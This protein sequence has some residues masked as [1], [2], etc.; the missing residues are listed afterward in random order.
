MLVLL[1]YA[2]FVEISK[3]L[4]LQDMKS[5]KTLRLWLVTL[6][7]EEGALLLE[8]CSLPQIPY[9]IWSAGEWI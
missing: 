7:W 9:Q 4:N 6:Y 8:S 3:M 1:H 2:G 5:L